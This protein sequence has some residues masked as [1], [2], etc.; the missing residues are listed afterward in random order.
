MTI[1]DIALQA[2]G[3]GLC[4]VPPREDGTKHPIGPWKRYQSLRPDE[5]QLHAWYGT[6][7]RRGLGLICGAISGNLEMLEFE[8]KAVEAG[9][10]H[11]FRELAEQAGLGPV[12]TRINSGYTERTPSGG[13][14]LLYHCETRVDGN[15]KLARRP[16]TA[17]ELAI[18]PQDRIKVLIETRGEGGYVITAPSNGGVHPTGGAWTLLAGGFDQVVTITAAEREALLDLARSLDQM[19]HEPV[20]EPAG[21]GKAGE[22]PGDDFNAR[23][24][25]PDILE[26]YGWRALFVASDGNQHWRRPGKSIGTSA[27]ISERGDGLLYVFTSSTEFD[28]PRAYSK[29]GAYAALHH[30]GD[31]S[32]AAAELRRQGYGE[33]V[34]ASGE[35][36]E[37]NAQPLLDEEADVPERHA[38]LPPFPIEALPA[39]AAEWVHM[40]AQSGLP[41]DYLGCAALGVLATAVGGNLSLAVRQGW[42]EPMILWLAIVGEP[43]DRKSPSIKS[44]RQP[45]DVQQVRWMTAFNEAMESWKLLTPKEQKDQPK[46]ICK[47]V[48]VGDATMEVLARIMAENESGVGLIANELRAVLTGLGQYKSGTNSD[49]PRFLELW[50]GMPWTIDRAG[51]GT[52]AVPR[53]AMSI[54][55]GLQPA[56][57]GVLEGQDGL[58]DR[59]L[60]CQPMARPALRLRGLQAPDA[61]AAI[62]G[63]QQL[64]EVLT[65][66]R[67]RARSRYLSQDDYEAFCAAHDAYMDIAEN[68]SEPEQV[69]SFA[70]KAPAHLARI[71]LCLSEASQSAEAVHV[72]ASLAGGSLESAMRLMEYFMA[73]RRQLRLRPENLM[74]RPFDRGQDEAV[75]MLYDWLRRIPGGRALR[76]DVKHA[77]VAGVRTTEDVK[78][79]LQHYERTYPGCVVE[80]APEAG[81]PAAMVVY[82]P[83]VRPRGGDQ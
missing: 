72:T 73:H 17:E 13:L 19:P 79:L 76:R 75:E 8:G 15:T 77:H 80:E 41:D 7:G 74:R 64:V 60:I 42:D 11:R 54:V 57:L 59:F 49:R 50:D 52:I 35:A 27:T 47:R 4:P 82:L 83:G 48:V 29:F 3:A 33:S 16:A 37:T 34:K 38:G 1:L 25:W 63:W 56:L 46:P 78:A 24:R 36:R 55:G 18:E 44:A 5:G 32:A 12:L 66:R 61:T 6:E 43:G 30:A 14:H 9:L 53:P 22:R 67:F 20:R 39:Q 81:G 21:G 65:S 23:A 45:L 28:S 40:M 51:S 68:P 62:Q 2:H 10:H 58:R 71:A 31:H 26:P 70:R 69:R